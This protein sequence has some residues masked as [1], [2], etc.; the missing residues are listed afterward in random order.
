MVDHAPQAK[1]LPAPLLNAASEANAKIVLVLGAGCSFPPPTSVPM[2]MKCAEEAYRRLKHDGVLTDGDCQNPDD[3]SILADA[4]FNKRGSQAELVDRLPREQ[5]RRARANAG[6]LIAAALLRENVISSILT[7][8]YDLAMEDALT[9]LGALTVHMIARPED[10][11]HFVAHNVV[12]LHRNVNEVDPE[13]W[14]LRGAALASEWQQGWEGMMAQVMLTSS[15][16]VFV[17]LGSPAAVLIE[18]ARLIKE[19][20]G[21]VDAYQIDPYP[22]DGNAFFQALALAPEAFV[23][24]GWNEFMAQL[25]DRV[26]L[27]QIDTLRSICAAEAQA[28]AFAITDADLIAG[29]LSRAGLVEVGKI[30]A[31]WLSLDECYAVHTSLNASLLA[32]VVIAASAVA[33][34][35]DAQDVAIRSEVVEFRGE[36][37]ETLTCAMMASG[38][39]VR[40]WT[41]MEAE[42]RR[43]RAAVPPHDPQPRFAVVAGATGVP[44]SDVVAPPDIVVESRAAGDIVD[45]EAPFTLLNAYEICKSPETLHAVL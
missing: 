7:L 12:Y 26:V 45:D 34:A 5:F 3:L 10:M 19:R 2:A 32:H 39:G 31:A 43:R 42:V 36:S 27:E 41:A 23:Q 16:V 30:R 4:V 13:K 44:L 15:V 24:L 29:R 37:G 21:T 9:Q 1:P 35:V 20:I 14:V 40:G 33:Q 22:V 6:Y 25:G 11:P 8:N 17:G 28:E 38:R 18:T